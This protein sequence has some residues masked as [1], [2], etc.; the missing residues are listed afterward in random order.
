[1]LDKVGG[2]RYLLIL[3]LI[4]SRTTA[5][6]PHGGARPRAGLPRI[7]SSLWVLESAAM[8]SHSYP[9]APTAPK[10]LRDRAPKLCSQLT[11]HSYPPDGKRERPT[12]V[13]RDAPGRGPTP[14]KK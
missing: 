4:D 14:R 3:P 7:Q 1:M 8:P 9:E 10:T 5:A 12:T 6:V 2:N 11:P 13:M